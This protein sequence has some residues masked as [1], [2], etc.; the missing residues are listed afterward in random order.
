MTIPTISVVIPTYNSQSTI[1]AALE[2]VYSQSI[3][4]DEIIVVDDESTDNTC[5]TVTSNFPQV[6]L[7]QKSN[8]GPSRARN[9]GLEQARF[10]W[11]AF[12][13][14]DDIWARDK[15]EKQL[16]AAAEN[17][18][19]VLVASNWTQSAQSL[20]KDSSHDLHTRKLWT[21]D[22]LVL[23]RFQT[24]TVMA[25][26][27]QLMQ[28]KGFKSELDGAEDWDMWLRLSRLGEVIL[29]EEPLVYYRDSEGGYSKDLT[30]LMLATRKMMVREVDESSLNPRLVKRIWAWHYLRFC[31][32]FLLLK[33]AGGARNS[34][35]S[36]IRDGLGRQLPSAAWNYLVPFLG[37]RARRRLT[38]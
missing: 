18:R 11:V 12:L 6:R 3:P 27:A 1:R 10:E 8:G 7:F 23:N 4:I 26:R 14:A 29:L 17:P 25:R 5:A 28:L 33:D 37:S 22:I 24:S 15:C 21:S 2:S 36:A 20:V 31:V 35:Q 34:L 30:R 32:G 13:D 16:K 19:A 9:H 38:R